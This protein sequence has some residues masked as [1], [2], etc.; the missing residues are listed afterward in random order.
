[1]L[2]PKSIRVDSIV[3]YFYSQ[4]VSRLLLQQNRHFSDL[5]RCPETWR[6]VQ[7][8][9]AMSNFKSATRSKADVDQSL[10]TNLDL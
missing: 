2:I 8:L 7:R 5:A 6:D 1:M 10:L 3:L 4:A 9:G